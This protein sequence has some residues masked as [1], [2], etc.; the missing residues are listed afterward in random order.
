MREVRNV[1]TMDIEKPKKFERKI[2]EE[3]VHLTQQ[4]KREQ[5]KYKKPLF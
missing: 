4:A 5:S 2:K 3:T 1:T